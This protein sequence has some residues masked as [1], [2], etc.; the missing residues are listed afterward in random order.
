MSHREAAD[1]AINR[2]VTD[3]AMRQGTWAMMCLWCF[4]TNSILQQHSTVSV[5]TPVALLQY[6]S[7]IGLCDIVTEC[8]S[9]GRLQEA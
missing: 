1:H 8:M 7:Y 5:Q 6:C 3:H 2:T 4:A 9:K